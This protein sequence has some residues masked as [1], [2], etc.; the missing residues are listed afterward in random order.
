[1]WLSCNHAWNVVTTVAIIVIPIK[2]SHTL[3]REHLSRGL[4]CPGLALL[5]GQVDSSSAIEVCYRTPGMWILLRPAR[6]P[7]LE[8]AL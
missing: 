4:T 2:K 8:I 3:S 5:S 6:H 7:S 1:M